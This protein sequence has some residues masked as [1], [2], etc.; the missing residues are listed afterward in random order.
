MLTTANNNGNINKSTDQTELTPMTSIN[1]K[2]NLNGSSSINKN[3]ELNESN[4]NNEKQASSASS[5][6]SNSRPSSG[7]FAIATGNETKNEPIG[8]NELNQSPSK[9]L[10][11][12]KTNDQQQTKS[13]IH[14]TSN[15]QDI[16]FSSAPSSP[17]ISNENLTNVLESSIDDDAK[18][19]AT[20]KNATTTATT[21]QTNKKNSISTNLTPMPTSSN[22]L[23]GV[24][25]S[26]GKDLNVKEK[27]KKPWYSVSRIFYIKFHSISC[28][29][30]YIKVN[31]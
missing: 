18:M 8:L 7:L 1:E 2:Q 24:V 4:N 15:E 6:N 30:L 14:S 29:Y 28:I 19:I 5:S 10:L 9:L 27:H 16:Q 26:Q 17:V 21:P 11:K 13:L 12:S 23:N 31:N 22:N 25:G 20:K 3:L